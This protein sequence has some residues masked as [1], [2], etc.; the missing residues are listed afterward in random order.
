MCPDLPGGK[1]GHQKQ[2][3]TA[4]PAQV[5]VFRTARGSSGNSVEE[6]SRSHPVRGWI[7]YACPTRNDEGPLQCF[8]HKSDK[9]QQLRRSFVGFL[10]ELGEYQE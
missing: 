3:V 9:N 1:E 4:G 2:V 5:S 10:G 6:E 7:C 8:Q